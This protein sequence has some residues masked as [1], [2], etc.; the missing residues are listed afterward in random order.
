MHIFV[1]VDRDAA[2]GATVVGVMRT[3]QSISHTHVWYYIVKLLHT[4]RYVHI[5]FR[6]GLMMMPALGLV[7]GNL[8]CACLALVRAATSRQKARMKTMLTIDAAAEVNR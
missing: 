8:V 6:R 1:V 5:A 7:V 4:L 3:F 2:N